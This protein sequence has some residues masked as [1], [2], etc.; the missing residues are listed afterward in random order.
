LGTC[1]GAILLSDPQDKKESLIDATINRNAYGRQIDSFQADI[2]T[3]LLGRT[4]PGVFIRAPKFNS[5]VSAEDIVAI[6]EGEVVGVRKEN[7]LA[8]TFHPEL[9]EDVG[10]HRW[11][12]ER[13]STIMEAKNVS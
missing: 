12:I 7:R 9:S 8:L 11:L 3:P 1:A 6:C 5:D 4:F 13:A 10:F 2:Q